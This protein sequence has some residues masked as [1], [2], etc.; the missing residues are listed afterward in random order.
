MLILASQ[1]INYNYLFGK[2]EQLGGQIDPE[3]KE[4][5]GPPF[6]PV[7]WAI[8]AWVLGGYHRIDLLLL[9]VIF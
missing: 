1:R 7:E 5:R 3:R 2:S 8:L 9:F 6:T 4:R